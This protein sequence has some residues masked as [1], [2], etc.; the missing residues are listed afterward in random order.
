MSRGNLS[1]DQTP[2]KEKGEQW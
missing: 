2:R 1:D